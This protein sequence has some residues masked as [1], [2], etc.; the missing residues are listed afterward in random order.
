MTKR[1][2]VSLLI[3]G[4]VIALLAILFGVVFCLRNQNVKVVGDSPINVSRE[5]II[6]SAGINNGQS[7]FMIDKNKA[8]SNIEAKYSHIKVIQIKTTNL[9]SIEIRVRARHEMFYAQANEK[10]Y[11]LDEELKVL[12]ILETTSSEPSQLIK[13]ETG[14]LNIDSASMM[15]DFLGNKLQQKITYNLFVAMNTVVTKQDEGNDVYLTR[16][17]IRATLLNINF[18]DYESYNKIVITT[19]YGV[20]LDIEKPQDDMQNKINICFS[21]IKQF[22]ID[23]KNKEQSG[24]IK[25]FY[26]INRNLKSIYIPDSVV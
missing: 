22:I 5:E 16:D 25:I 7:I 20:K 13:I 1:S 17:D 15:C 10:Y 19:K 26:D 23:A 8:I 9:M 14:D 24:T 11:I 12:D 3:C 21:T 18:E 4:G 6:S 2:V